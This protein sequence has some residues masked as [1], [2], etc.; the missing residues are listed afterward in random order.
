MQR[1]EVEMWFHENRENRAVAY[2]RVKETIDQAA[3]TVIDHAVIEEVSYESVL[4]DMPSEEIRRLAVREEVHLL[5]CDDIMFLR[6]Q[7]SI[8][9][10]DAV[11]EV[12]LEAE[13]PAK[14][15]DALPPVAA[16][17]D[18]IPVQ[19]HDLLVGRLDLDDPDGLEAMSIVAKRHHGTAIASLIVHGD[20]NVAGQALSRPL[21]VRPVLCALVGKAVTKPFSWYRKRGDPG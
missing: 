12:E 5:V 6:P 17:L 11:A 18:G 4:V 13:V 10:P 3:G 8:D 16:L 20:L 9:L 19:N 21:H 1:I 14:E 7:S 15:L 2:R